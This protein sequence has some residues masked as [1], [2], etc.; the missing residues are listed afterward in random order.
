MSA[1]AAAERDLRRIE[2]GTRTMMR[3]IQSGMEELARVFDGIRALVLDEKL[4]REAIAT[5]IDDI[6]GIIVEGFSI[7][8][9]AAPSL[10]HATIDKSPH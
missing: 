10:Q 2:A 1:Q 7:P 9:D 8:R 5:R 3:F 6:K 4:S